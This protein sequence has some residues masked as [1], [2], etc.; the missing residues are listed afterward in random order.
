MSSETTNARYKRALEEI[1][2]GAADPQAV[3]MEALRSRKVRPTYLWKA[4]AEASKKRAQDRRHARD[5]R[6]KAA[7]QDWLAS[8]RPPI[9]HY[10]RAKGMPPTSMD[11]LLV[12]GERAMAVPQ[13]LTRLSWSR[14]RTYDTYAEIWKAKFGEEL[15]ES[16]S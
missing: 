1:A 7:Y 12:R 11:R 4:E 3:A 10:A 5:E 8:G 13:R 15:S 9:A 14:N 2:A 16:S 6:A